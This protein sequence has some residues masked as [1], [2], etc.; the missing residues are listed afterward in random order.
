MSFKGYTSF[1]KKHMDLRGLGIVVLGL[2]LPSIATWMTNSGVGSRV[3]SYVDMVPGMTT[4]YGKAVIAIGLTA[5][6]SYLAANFGVISAAE[7][8]T[9]NMIAMGLVSV[10][11]LKTM[12]LPVGQGLVDNLPA[13]NFGG[14]AGSASYGYIGN[15]HEGV[16][17]EMLPAPQSQQLFGVRA[18]IF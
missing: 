4:K 6:V 18:N 10:G 7:A 12:S 2:G 11:L 13:A 3:M 8:L 14:L 16:G 1:V 15:Y 9:A 17:A 5:G